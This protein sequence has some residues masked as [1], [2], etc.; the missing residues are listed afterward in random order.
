MYVDTA[1]RLVRSVSCPNLTF[2][3]EPRGPITKRRRANS[4]NIYLSSRDILR[5][6]SDTDLLGIDKDKTFSASAIVKPAELLARVVNVLGGFEPQPQERGIHMFNDEEILAS[7]KL[8][9]FSIGQD[10]IKV[11]LR[12]P[13]HVV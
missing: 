3:V 8:P 13:E 1:P 11:H 2:D 10:I 5:I 9:V 12:G 6:Q 4:E 7:E